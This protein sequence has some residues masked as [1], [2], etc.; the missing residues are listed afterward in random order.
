MFSLLRRLLVSGACTNPRDCIS[1]KRANCRRLQLLRR[2]DCS[3]SVGKV[4]RHYVVFRVLYRECDYGEEPT[5]HE[6]LHKKRSRTNEGR[7][8]QPEVGK[9]ADELE[10][11]ECIGWLADG[12]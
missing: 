7:M 10:M 12:G 11:R 3:N 8:L 9:A 2:V 4:D 6:L 1:L 5:S